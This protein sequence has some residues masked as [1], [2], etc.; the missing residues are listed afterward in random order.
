M[1]KMKFLQAFLI[2]T[3]FTKLQF[4]KFDRH[5]NIYKNNKGVA[6]PI[7]MIN[8]PNWIRDAIFDNEEIEKF[9][10]GIM[11]VHCKKSEFS[12]LFKRFD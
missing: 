3:D 12:H 2:A 1:K 10:L 8:V 11:Y 6:S 4:Q 7:N 5:S 9:Y